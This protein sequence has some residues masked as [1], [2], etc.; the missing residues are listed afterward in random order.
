MYGLLSASEGPTRA[1]TKGSL[2]PQLGGV[3]AMG[4]YGSQVI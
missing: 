1:I 4:I 3:V 2:G